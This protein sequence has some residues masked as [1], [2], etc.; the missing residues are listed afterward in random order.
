MSCR[1]SD[2]DVVAYLKE[3]ETKTQKALQEDYE[4]RLNQIQ[5]NG[6]TR[7]KRD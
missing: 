7:K 3:Q 2:S 1:K 5:H 4:H 6:E